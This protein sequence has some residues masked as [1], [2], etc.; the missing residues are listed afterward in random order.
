MPA[1]DAYVRELNIEDK[2]LSAAVAYAR[3]SA[4]AEYRLLAAA[5]IH[6][7]DISWEDLEPFLGRGRMPVLET[8]TLSELLDHAKQELELVAWAQGQDDAFGCDRFV[9]LASILR[10]IYQRIHQG[11]QCTTS[12]MK[13]ARNMHRCQDTVEDAVPMTAKMALLVAPHEGD[14]EEAKAASIADFT[15]KHRLHLEALIDGHLTV[16][17]AGEAAKLT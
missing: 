2:T 10:Q 17:A 11:R 15:E 1:I 13:V 6:V 9:M 7:D 8:V 4:A 16:S 5:G 3:W 12:E 14:T